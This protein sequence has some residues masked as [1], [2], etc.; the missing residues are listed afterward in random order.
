MK[1]WIRMNTEPGALALRVQKGVKGNPMWLG[2][3][4]EAEIPGG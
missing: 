2:A 1:A 3:A 4:G